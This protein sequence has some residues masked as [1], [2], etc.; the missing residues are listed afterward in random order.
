MHSLGPRLSNDAFERP[1]A[2]RERWVDLVPVTVMRIAVLGVMT[3]MAIGSSAIGGETNLDRVPVLLH[4]TKVRVL[5]STAGVPAW[6]LKRCEDEHGRIAEPGAHFFATDVYST[7]GPPEGNIPRA[8]PWWGSTGDGRRYPPMARLE[9]VVTDGSTYVVQVEHG[10]FAAYVDAFV[11]GPELG[12]FRD[13]GECPDQC[14][15]SPKRLSAF[16]RHVAPA[17]AH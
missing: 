17:L 3:A 10:G 16:I 13:V 8:H 6:I 4:N 7:A 14:V 9:W 2:Q 12:H 15:K 1:T 5:Q 11:A